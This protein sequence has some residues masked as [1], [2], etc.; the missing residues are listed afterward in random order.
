MGA[1]AE[2]ASHNQA[3]G[4]VYKTVIAGQPHEQIVCT[5]PSRG[6]APMGI[7]MHDSV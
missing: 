7:C 5:C 3:R 6:A 1:A 2:R 4:L